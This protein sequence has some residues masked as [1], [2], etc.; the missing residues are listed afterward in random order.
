MLGSRPA[1]YAPAI[2]ARTSARPPATPA[3]IF[4]SLGRT[5]FLLALVLCDVVLVVDVVDVV[6]ELRAEAGGNCANEILGV[7]GIVRT[8]DARDD[9]QC[10]S[11]GGKRRDGARG[12]TLMP[13]RTIQRVVLSL[14]HNR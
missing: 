6:V 1:W 12:E 10:Q 11:G 7:I 5:L 9:T 3:A 14:V 2:S 13:D 4:C 8:S